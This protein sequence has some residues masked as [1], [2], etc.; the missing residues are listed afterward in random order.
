MMLA[1]F[2][3]LT[4]IVFGIFPSIS[5]PNVSIVHRSVRDSEI[6]ESPPTGRS[7]PPTDAVRQRAERFSAAFAGSTTRTPED[8]SVSSVVAR[9]SPGGEAADQ[10][11]Q[12][13]SLV[14]RN[15]GVVQGQQDPATSV[16][17]VSQPS[18]SSQH[19]PLYPP[20]HPQAM[21][22]LSPWAGVSIF[23]KYF[24]I[25]RPSSSS[26]HAYD[27]AMPLPTIT[28]HSEFTYCAL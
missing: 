15:H 3:A 5:R 17:S 4:P 2:F 26:K 12:L 9:H 20:I 25:H 8:S 21:P 7:L 24:T 28:G 18:V 10:D 19:H 16:P 6:N 23:A 22:V 27:G 11:L 1:I 13:A 14:P